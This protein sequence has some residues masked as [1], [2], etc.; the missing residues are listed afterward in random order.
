MSKED[1]IAEFIKNSKD[2][3]YPRINPF[4]LET[5]GKWKDGWHKQYIPKKG[6]KR[7]FLKILVK[8]NTVIEAY[9]R[10]NGEMI[11]VK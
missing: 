1:R 11:Q 4:T 3:D 2:P 9:R 8:D 10:K 6:G 5:H 7:L